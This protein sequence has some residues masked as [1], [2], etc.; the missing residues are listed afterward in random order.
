M[1]WTKGYSARYYLSVVDKNTMRDIDRIELTGGSI[2]RSM[3]DLRESA[4]LD[5][6]NYNSNV[7]Q[8][9][10]VWLD[11]KQGGESSHTPLFTG[12]ATSPTDKYNG[13]LKTNTVECYS[14]LKIASD[15][16]L[17]RGW[18]APVEANSGD[19]IRDLLSVTKTPI[20]IAENA[21]DISISI[22]AESGENHLSMSEK[23]LNAMNWRMRLDGYGS[24]FIEPINRDPVAY[25]SSNE[26][27]IIENDI[28]I[29]YDWFSAPNVLRCVLDDA[30][31]EARDDDPDSPLSTVNR[32]REVWYED[33]DVFL[34]SNETLA[35]YSQRML[36]EYQRTATN[37]SYSRRYYPNVYPG[38]VVRLNYAA[39]NV[40]GNFLVTD[41]SISLGYS[42][43][44]SE[45]VYKI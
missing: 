7:E 1:D 25:F 26:N 20:T 42:A 17:P 41:Q 37:I 36:K 4:S 22:I 38:D 45:E 30:Y 35:E 27:D 14:I 11:T 29:T 16:M 10:R 34:N 8:Y 21:P 40:M 43:K 12:I 15:I 9:I 3:S 32:G 5:C 24:I 31:A 18:Y 28:S 13:R 39:Q 33:T 19:L 6:V 44:T 23:L 2:R